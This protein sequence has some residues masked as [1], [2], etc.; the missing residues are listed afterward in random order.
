MLRADRGGNIYP[1]EKIHQDMDMGPV[2]YLL[3]YR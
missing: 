3:F 1:V 2:L